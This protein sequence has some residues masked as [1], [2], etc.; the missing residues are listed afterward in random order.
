MEIV[1]HIKETGI[2]TKYIEPLN[3]IEFFKWHFSEM[4]E[5]GN[6]FLQNAS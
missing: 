5:K 6:L 3:W 4:D 1:S 2:W